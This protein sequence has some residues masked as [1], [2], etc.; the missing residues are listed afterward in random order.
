MAR[1]NLV[2]K[3]EHAILK[4]CIDLK[5]KNV[6]DIIDSNNTM[7]ESEEKCFMLD[8][9]TKLDRKMLESIY[10]RGFSRIPVFDDK[11]EDIIGILMTK[12]LIL[13]NPDRDNPTI[14]QIS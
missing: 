14:E 6:F 5:E 9:Q 12:D 10:Q 7:I 2:E 1:D 3:T 11:R 13:M 8:L 4:A